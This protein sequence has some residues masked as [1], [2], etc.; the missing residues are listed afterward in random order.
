[1]IYGRLKNIS[2]NQTYSGANFLYAG[3]VNILLLH[4]LHESSLKSSDVF[5]FQKAVLERTVG[6]PRGPSF[7]YTGVLE[8]VWDALSHRD[9]RMERAGTVYTEYKTNWFGA[10]VFI[11]VIL[12]FFWRTRV[13]CQLLC[14]RRPFCIFE[15]CLWI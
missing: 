10:F 9:A 12:P 15:I 2:Y 6:C 3:S 7:T 13:C 11:F 4:I 5:F 1:M 8:G 14:F